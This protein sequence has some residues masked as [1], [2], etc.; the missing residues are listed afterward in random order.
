MALS[1]D[2]SSTEYK[3]HVITDDGVLE[4]VVGISLYEHADPIIY[5]TVWDYRG[6]APGE[7][8]SGARQHTAARSAQNIR[9]AF[10]A[11]DKK[12]AEVAL[13]APPVRADKTE[14][15]DADR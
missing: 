2:W 13:M 10:D 6:K 7:P 5:A 4:G 9:E 14:S 15:N 1:R 8:F 11:C 12:L 3:R